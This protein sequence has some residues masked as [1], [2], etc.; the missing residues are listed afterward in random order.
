MPNI[1][2]G[3]FRLRGKLEDI[4]AFLANELESLYP[5]E[6]SLT[7]TWDTYK[8]E[9]PNCVTGELSGELDDRYGVYIK[10]SKR[11]FILGGSSDYVHLLKVKN[12]E[13]KYIMATPYHAAWGIDKDIMQNIC[14]RY[15]LDIK[16]NGYDCG[17]QY[18]ATYEVK[19]I[20][21]EIPDAYAYSVKIDNTVYYDGTE[22]EW[23]CVMPYLGG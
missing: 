8:D 15:R 12:A 23:N 17:M 1:F 7:I 18:E 5:S 10:G 22:W 11:Q 6:S 19:A 2:E 16:V 13:N 20:S 9:Y 21:T 3:T 4:K 14:K